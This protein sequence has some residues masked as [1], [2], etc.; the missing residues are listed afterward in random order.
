MTHLAKIGLSLSAFLFPCSFAVKA[1]E[2][3]DSVDTYQ[4]QIVNTTVSVQGRTLLTTHDVNVTSTGHLKMSAPDGIVATG[5]FTVDHGG[6]LEL[7]GGRQYYIIFT[8]DASGNRIL[9]RKE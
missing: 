3:N 7:D 6:T 9:R 4:N 8:Y 5:P 1:M 2:A